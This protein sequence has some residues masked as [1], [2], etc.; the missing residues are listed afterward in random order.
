MQHH[1]A[2][3]RIFVGLLQ[4]WGAACFC[5]FDCAW[6]LGEAAD[7]NVAPGRAH[8]TYRVC[9]TTEMLSSLSTSSTVPHVWA[10]ARMWQA[11]PIPGWTR[12]SQMRSRGGG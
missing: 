5:H 9:S 10:V 1:V 12:R 8:W 11:R 6:H 3:E 2:W 7:D 4:V